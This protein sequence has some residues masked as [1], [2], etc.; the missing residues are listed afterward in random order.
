VGDVSE[1]SPEGVSEVSD[2]VL[3]GV[4]VEV[5]EQEPTDE[6]QRSLRKT[7]G[8]YLACWGRVGAR[9]KG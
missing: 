9:G 6:R 2:A 4:F 5:R 7:V 3:Q 8:K 1:E